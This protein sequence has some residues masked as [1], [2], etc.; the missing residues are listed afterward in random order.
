[1]IT[2]IRSQLPRM[3]ESDYVKDAISSPVILISQS[4][5]LDK[6]LENRK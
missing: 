1:M 2:V 4:V 6:E 3:L 5:K